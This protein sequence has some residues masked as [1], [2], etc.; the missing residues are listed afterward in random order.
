MSQENL[1]RVEQGFRLYVDTGELDLD[2]L[3]EDADIYDHD[4][5]EEGHYVGRAGFLKWLTDWAEAWETWSLEPEEFIDA[6]DKVVIVFR[7][8]AKGR[9]SGIEVDRRDS[10][11]YEFR[12]DTIVRA[13]YFN[14]REQGIQAAGLAV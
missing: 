14:S 11:V 3:A 10:L 13:D 8:R 4:I 2:R 1:E 5:P 9:A 12:G 7:L 6:G